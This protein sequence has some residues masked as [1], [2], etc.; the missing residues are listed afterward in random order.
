MTCVSAALL[1]FLAIPKAWPH[2]FMCALVGS[3]AV[4]AALSRYAGGSLQYIIANTFSRATV[5]N[6]KLAVIDPPYNL[7]G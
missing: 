1:L 6:F 4:V 3:Y 2:I 7:A 5:T